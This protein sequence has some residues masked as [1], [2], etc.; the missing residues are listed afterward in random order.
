MQIIVEIT[1]KY[2]LVDR[3]SPINKQCE[4]YSDENRW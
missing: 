4:N 1:S 3:K 2:S